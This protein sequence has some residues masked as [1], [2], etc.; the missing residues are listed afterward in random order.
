MASLICCVSTGHGTWGYVYRL[1]R[2]LP[3]D[4]IYIVTNDFGAQKF[5]KKD[6]TSLVVVD[7]NKPLNDLVRDI[8]EKL[9][10][11]IK[12][13]EVAVNMISGTGKEHMAIISAVIKLG[14]GIRLVALTEKGLEEI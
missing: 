8:K 13:F 6:N 9:Y 5:E 3:W 4:H 10:G 1:I 12:D 7:F 11:K 14:L 2:E